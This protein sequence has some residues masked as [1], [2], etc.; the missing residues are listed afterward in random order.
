M[1]A[2]TVRNMIIALDAPKAN[3]ARLKA[4]AYIKVAGKSEAYPGP[5][6]VK[7]ITRSKL[8]IAICD[9]IITELI[10]TGR[11]LGIIIRR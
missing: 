10:N 2:I 3:R 6:R 1:M 7:T 11:K 4:K 5:P 8:L 9:R